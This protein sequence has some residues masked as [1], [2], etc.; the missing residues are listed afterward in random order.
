MKQKFSVEVKGREK[1]YGFIFEGDPEHLQGWL[2]DGLEVY[3]VTNII[4]EWA[5]RMGLTHIWCRVQDA[6]NFLRFW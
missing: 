3:E 6:W 1:S 2:D 5:Q 4:P